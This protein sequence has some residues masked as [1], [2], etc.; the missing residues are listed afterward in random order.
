MLSGL[1]EAAEIVIDR[2]GIPHIYAASQTDAFFVQ[3]FNAARDRLWQIDL[4]RKR[5]LGLLAGELGPAY[6]ERDRA[7]RLLLYRGDMA[8]E[9]ASYGAEA[10][11]RTN[12]LRRGD[13]CLYR[14]GG[15]GTG[16]P[17]DRVPGPEDQAPPD[18]APRMSCAA[19]RMPGSATSTPK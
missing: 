19:G 16:A 18:G 6:V 1:G 8:A 14:P 2:W 4:W 12:R 5:G 3:G 15:A 13:Q 10:Q 7:A 9:W 11:S 17:P